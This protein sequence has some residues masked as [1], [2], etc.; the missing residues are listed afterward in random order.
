MRASL[1][2]KRLC[3]SSP[4]PPLEFRVGAYDEQIRLDIRRT[5]DHPWFEPHRETLISI[6][7]TFST[8]NQS[9]GYPQ[10]LNYLVFPLFYVFHNDA[11]KTS[12]EDTFYALQ[13][14]VRIVLP[15][16]PLNSKDT[17]ALRVIESVSNLVCLEC[18]GKEP[19]LEILFS[20]TH[21]PF[22][23]SLVTCMLPTLYANVFQLQDTLLLWDRIFEKP[24]FH[25]MFDASVRVLV[26]SMLY[27]KNMFLH[28]PV[29][30]CMELFQRTL[31]ESISVCASI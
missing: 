30:K 27:H 25:A 12:V 14:L 23:T 6:L 29:T 22:V 28:L 15:V 13:S 21:K 31:K 11:P 18:W 5:S 4:Y 7:N 26:E 1:W 20:E 19:A 17:S 24:D 8:V 3:P 10:G 9:F 16:Y 2:R